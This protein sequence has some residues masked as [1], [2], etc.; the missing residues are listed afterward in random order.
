MFGLIKKV[1]ILVLV[2]TAN[3]LKCILLKNQECRVRRLIVNN[4]YITYPY[5]IKVNRYNGNCNNISNSYPRVCNISNSYPRVCIL[6]ITKIFTLKIFDLMTLTN[7]TKQIIFHKSCKYDV[8]Y[9]LFVTINKSGIKDRCRCKCR[10]ECLINKK[11][12]NKFWNPN[13]CKCE[14]RAAQLT[15]KCKEIAD[16]KTLSIKN[17]TDVS[18]KN[19]IKNVIQ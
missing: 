7:K 3:S 14:Y 17:K 4:E 10:C 8:D 1:L 16:N 2:S 15:E 18:T 6:D 9:L 13:G 12:S 11:C 5:S 19:I